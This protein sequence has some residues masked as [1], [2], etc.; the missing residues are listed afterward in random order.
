M[1]NQRI[2]GTPSR[3]PLSQIQQVGGKPG[4]WFW[5]LWLTDLFSTFHIFNLCF[6]IFWSVDCLQHEST[7]AQ[8]NKTQQLCRADTVKLLCMKI[9]IFSFFLNQRWLGHYAW[10]ST[11]T[12]KILE[13]CTKAKVWIHFI[14]T[15]LQC[16][17]HA[18][19]FHS[20]IYFS[21]K[22]SRSTA[23]TSKNL[24][25]KKQ[26]SGGVSATNMPR[27]LSGITLSLNR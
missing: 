19:A 16:S 13:I 11:S 6:L 4:W 15:N 3:G 21:C 2:Y 18:S 27:H 1:K 8:H 22:P 25:S 17:Q 24:N 23:E 9:L 5:M 10:G 12:D 7:T 26:T 14:L 20:H